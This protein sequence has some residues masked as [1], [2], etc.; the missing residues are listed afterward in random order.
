MQFPNCVGGLEKLDLISVSNQSFSP[1]IADKYGRR[2][3]IAIGCVIMI[4]GAII[5][6]VCNGYGMYVGGRFLLGFGNSLAQLAS[7]VLITEICHPQ[8][9]ARVSAV[10]NCLWN[11]GAV[12]VAWA[13]WGTMQIKGDWSWRAIT[14]LQGL[15]SVIQILG[16]YCK[17]QNPQR[18]HAP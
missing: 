2:L 5:C 11:V 9:R 14:I 12:L 18:N 7:P 4:V 3:P 1:W 13:A 15:P 16:I 17:Y 8:H 6:G 10:Y